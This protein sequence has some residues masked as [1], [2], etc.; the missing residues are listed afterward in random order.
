MCPIV[1]RHTLEKRGTSVG[2]ATI[3]NIFFPFGFIGM[4]T[5]V[6]ILDQAANARPLSIGAHPPSPS[7]QSTPPKTDAAAGRAVAQ[8]TAKPL[9]PVASVANANS[10]RLSLLPHGGKRQRAGASTGLSAHHAQTIVQAGIASIICDRPF[11]RFITIH[12]GALGLGDDDAFKATAKLMTLARD[13]LRDRGATADWLWV[14]ENDEGDG[15]KGSHVHWLVHLPDAHRMAFLARLKGWCAKAAGARRYVANA[16][17]TR[18]IGQNVDSW[19]NAPDSHCANLRAVTAYLL[20]GL[21]PTAYHAACDGL[22]AI[23][24]GYGQATPNPGLAGYVIGKRVGVS[25]SLGRIATGPMLAL[26][27]L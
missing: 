5:N 6:N 16:L 14:R 21:P 22:D 24:Q 11:N 7:L 18:P 4:S 3:G 15:S 13:W 20:K 12:W 10:C 9:A 26:Q 1:P 8:A 17:M 19:C 2:L 27:F 25:K 23:W